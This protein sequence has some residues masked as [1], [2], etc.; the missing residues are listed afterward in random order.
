MVVLD[1][2]G[3]NLRLVL[4]IDSDVGLGLGPLEIRVERPGRKRTVG[5]RVAVRYDY[6]GRI[7]ISECDS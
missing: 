1:V 4:R 2:D 5:V 3:D 6:Y 7:L